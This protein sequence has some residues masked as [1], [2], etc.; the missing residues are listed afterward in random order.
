MEIRSI[1]YHRPHHVNTNITK[2]AQ[3]PLCSRIIVGV[4]GHEGKS[5]ILQLLLHKLNFKTGRYVN[6]LQANVNNT[7]ESERLSFSKRC[8]YQTGS[9]SRRA[10]YL[11]KAS[12]G[13]ATL[14]CGKSRSVAY[15]MIVEV[16]EQLLAVF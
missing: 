15:D 11:S 8:Q 6:Y 9:M 13:S 14:V 4:L 5:W 7:A 3:K 2:S 16:A 12:P 1:S 10:K